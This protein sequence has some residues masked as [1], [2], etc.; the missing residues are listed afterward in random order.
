MRKRK[1]A[2]EKILAAE[3][4]E[5]IL[6]FLQEN[7]ECQ[8]VE[9]PRKKTPAIQKKPL[10]N[11]TGYTKK[12]LKSCI[13]ATSLQDQRLAAGECLLF[14]GT[15]I[16]LKAGK[17]VF[18]KARITLLSEELESSHATMTNANL[19]HRVYFF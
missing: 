6:K 4:T 18:S 15:F 12:N 16:F 7:R 1:L 19:M 13:I 11:E 10:Q 17:F 14:L 3:R 5:R 2:K 9:V 8:P